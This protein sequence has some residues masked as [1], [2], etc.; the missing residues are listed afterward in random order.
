MG[1]LFWLKLLSLGPLPLSPVPVERV[2]CSGLTCTK[3]GSTLTLTAS[4][5]G[6]SS[7]TALQA[8][9]GSGGFSAYAG[10]SCTN[11]FPRSLSAAG[12]ATCASVALG[13]DVSGTLPAANGGLGGAQPT[14]G[15][16]QYVTCN[17]STCS[18]ST[19]A[20]GG[21]GGTSPLVLLLG[22]L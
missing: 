9:N 21:G 13:T 14:C 10:T 15:A 2:V 18:C 17:G 8:G 7:G 3:I 5:G 6:S 12:A 1:F 11:Q 4:A 16:G 22:G 20:G 19:P